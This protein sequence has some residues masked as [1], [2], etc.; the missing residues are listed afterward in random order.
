MKL[1]HQ[2]P[3]HVM[4]EESTSSLQRTPLAAERDIVGQHEPVHRSGKAIPQP[5]KRIKRLLRELT[6]R[7]DAEA[8]GQEL[9]KLHG[10][11][12]AWQAGQLSPFDLGEEIHRFHQGPNRELF[13]LYGSRYRDIAVA[14]AIVEALLPADSVPE[15]V[16]AYLAPLL[17]M[18]QNR[19]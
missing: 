19:P 2:M 4:K 14:R 3:S 6:D 15:D 10:S 12:H 11:F 5:S 13:V 7:A 1:A 16:P 18:L 9:S 8:L 17:A